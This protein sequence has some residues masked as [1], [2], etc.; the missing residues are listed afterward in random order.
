MKISQIIPQLQKQLQEYGDIEV[1]ISTGPEHDHEA[2]AELFF[3]EE[4]EDWHPRL[5]I[6]P[7]NTFEANKHICTTPTTPTLVEAENDNEDNEDNEDEDT[8]PLDFLPEAYA[9]FPQC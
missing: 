9:R 6:T 4:D 3:A 5:L 2:S 7:G 8:N 1:V